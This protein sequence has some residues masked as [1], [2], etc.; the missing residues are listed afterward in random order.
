MEFREWTI[1]KLKDVNI[2]SKILFI[3]EANLYVYGEVNQQKAQYWSNAT[4]HWISQTK[5][6][7]T[8]KFMVCTKISGDRIIGPFTITS[9][10]DG[11]N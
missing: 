5:M 11:K 8:G 10:L 4:T 1:S 7:G 3:D 9:N 6:E 2:S